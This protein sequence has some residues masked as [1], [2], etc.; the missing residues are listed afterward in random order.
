M[1]WICLLRG[2]LDRDDHPDIQLGNEISGNTCHCINVTDSPGIMTS[3]PK[4]QGDTGDCVPVDTILLVAVRQCHS[5]GS[6]VVV[7]WLLS[8]FF[9]LSLIPLIRH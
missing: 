9:S 1:G 4:L 5:V 6:S 8:L 3:P 7:P 2:H